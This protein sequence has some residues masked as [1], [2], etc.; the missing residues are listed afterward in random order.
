[1]DNEIYGK[2]SNSGKYFEENVNYVK[3]WRVAFI[4]ERKAMGSFP[5]RGLFLWKELHTPAY[6]PG[7]G[8]CKHKDPELEP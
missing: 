6:L 4:L 2:T 5:M 1:M 7:R 3:A 8:K